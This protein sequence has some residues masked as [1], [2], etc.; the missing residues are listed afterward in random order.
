MDKCGA[1]GNE[2]NQVK[3]THIVVY[4]YVERMTVNGK[5]K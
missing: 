5:Y 3:S 2:M 1:V 4:E